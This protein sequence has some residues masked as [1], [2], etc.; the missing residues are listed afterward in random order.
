MIR[1]V[2]YFNVGQDTTHVGSA[3]F[4]GSEPWY[5][6]VPSVPSC[7][8]N[9]GL[10]LHNGTYPNGTTYYYSY[11]SYYVWRNQSK[12]TIN[13]FVITDLDK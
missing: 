12:Y 3:V 11:V 6:A 10:D 9:T 4:S 8:N 5:S 1:V 2:D 13:Y 7:P